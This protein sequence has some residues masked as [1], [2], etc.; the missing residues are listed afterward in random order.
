MLDLKE[1]GYSRLFF[2][3]HMAGSTWENRLH[4]IG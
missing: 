1:A 3:E 4:L 2:Y